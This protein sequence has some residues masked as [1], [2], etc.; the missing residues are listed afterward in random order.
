MK[1]AIFGIVATSLV[2]GFGGLPAFGAT[3]AK[4]AVDDRMHSVNDLVK[5]KGLMQEALKGVSVETGVPLGQVEAMHDHFKDTGA[6]GILVACVMADATKTA[7]EYFLKKHVDGGK[8]WT[9]LA[10]ENKVS[11]DLLLHKLENM[12]AH[13]AGPPVERPKR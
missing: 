9:E 2:L 1:K 10:Q 7:P 12:E 6:A 13:L 11:I 5:K 4:R 8:D 3:G